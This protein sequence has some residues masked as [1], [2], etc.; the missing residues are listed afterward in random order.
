MIKIKRMWDVAQLVLRGKFTTIN[1]YIGNEERCQ[2]GN[3]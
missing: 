1:A 2:L 3:Q